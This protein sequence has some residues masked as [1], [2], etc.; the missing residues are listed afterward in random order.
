[1]TLRELSEAIAI[2]KYANIPEHARP[3]K[4][5]KENSA[6]ELTKSILAY[7]EYNDIMAWRQASEGRYIKGK[8]YTDWAGR[9]KEEKGMYIPRSKGGKGSADVTATLPPYGRRLEIEVKYGKDRQSPVFTASQ[10]KKERWYINSSHVRH[11]EYEDGTL[12]VTF[13]NGRVY[14]YYNVPE[15]VWKKIDEA[16]SIGLVLARHVKGKFEFKEI[17]KKK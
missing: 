10:M 6:N 9:K 11:C 7:F 16:D 4:K 8:E 3:V 15:S 5:L 2:K 1:M 12:T 17:I 13:T 14:E